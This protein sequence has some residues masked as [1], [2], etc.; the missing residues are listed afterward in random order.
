VTTTYDVVGAAPGTA[1]A[2]AWRPRP[3]GAAATLVAARPE[4]VASAFAAAAAR[5][6]DLASS[7]RASGATESADILEAEALIARDPVFLEEAI[8]AVQSG[9]ASSA[10]AAVQQVAD[11]HAAAMELLESAMLRER[12]ADIRQVGRMVVEHLAGGRREPPAATSF[13]LVAEEITAP[14]LL[15][16]ADQ[17]VGAVSTRGGASSHAAIVARSLGVPLVVEAPGSAVEVPD[18]TLLLVDADRGRLVVSPDRHTLGG[19]RPPSSPTLG[20]LRPPSSPQQSARGDLTEQLTTA[21]GVGV[22][23]LA[24]IASAVEARRA[25]AAGAVGVGLVR[26]ELAFLDAPD[27]P[28]FVQH[29]LQLRPLLQ[30]L[31]GRPVSVR[32]LDFTNDKRPP[33]LRASTPNTSGDTLGLATL[34]HHPWALDEQLRAILSAGRDVGL[35]VLVPMVSDAHEVESVRRRL[36]S[37]LDGRAPV[38][39]GA[40]VE[41]PEAAERAAALAQA[42]DFL[43]LGT[44][45]LTAATLGL[46]RTDARLTPAMTAHPAVLRCVALTVDAAVAVGC[47]VS[48]C[49]DAAADPVV[50]PL[51]V[52]AGLRS[53]SVGVS[54]LGDVRAL[55]RGLDVPSCVDVFEQALTLSDEAAVQRLVT[56]EVRTSH[57]S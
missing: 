4:D 14:D 31:A 41:L 15:E 23:L 29:E 24:N 51:L 52:G 8:R 21:D 45:D 5:L 28:T 9:D 36:E 3:S 33:F 54:R 11:R 47:P 37:V 40:M 57:A 35:G 22:S 39:V 32:L 18:G 56:S 50:L 1:L 16:N 48:I 34:L 7:F 10:M 53:F 42:S 38:P 13:V 26:T 46:A 17:V 27:W 43:S 12:A 44:N 6:D 49:G 2:P 25:V 19:L 55:V 20:G 30:P